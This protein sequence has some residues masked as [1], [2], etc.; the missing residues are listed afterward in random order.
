MLETLTRAMIPGYGMPNFEKS[1]IFVHF[2]PLFGWPEK[3]MGT[4]CRPR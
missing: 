3:L 1:A 4:I 2:G